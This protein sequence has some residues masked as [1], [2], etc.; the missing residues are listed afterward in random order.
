MY[1]RGMKQFLLSSLLFF[2]LT[3]PHASYGSTIDR[4]QKDSLRYHQTIA[5]NQ[6]LTLQERIRAIDKSIELSKNQSDSLYLS[7]VYYKSKIYGDAKEYDA[8][9]DQANILLDNAIKLS[10]LYYQAQAY[11]KLGWYLDRNQ[12]T[13]EAFKNY[14]KSID[15]YTEIKDSINIIKVS[16]RASFIQSQIGDLDGAE[17]T[18]VNAL[19]YSAALDDTSELSWFYD[20]LGRVYRERS[21][22]QEAISNHRKALRLE[23]SPA[24]RI[25]LLNNYAITLIK[26]SRFNEAITQLETVL[27]Y[28]DLKPRTQ[29][30]LLD[31]LAFAKAKLKAPDA[32]KLLE[33][34]LN[35]RKQSNDVAGQYAS[36]IHLSEAYG[37]IENNDNK[38]RYH[39]QQAYDIAHQ[40]KNKEARVRALDFLIPVTRESSKL[41]EERRRLADSLDAAQN[42]AKFE[43][44]KLR[45]DVEKAEERESLALRLQSASEL[46]EEIA[47]RRRNWAFA[48]LVAFILLGVVFILYQRERSR[49]QRIQD[50]Y[51]TEKRLSK[52]LHDELANEIYLV[53]S[54]VES[55]TTAPA[56]ADKLEHIY[57]LSRDISRE[58]QPIQTGTSF[59]TELA[60]SLQTYTSSERKLILRGLES[61]SWNSINDEKKIEIYRILQE[62]MTNMRKHSNAS[63]VALVFKEVNK[64]L[65]INY[66][67]NGKGVELTSY[68]RGSGLTNTET[69][70]KSVGGKITFDSAINEGFRAELSIPI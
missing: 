57:K 54:Q 1:F 34:A 48:G 32:I 22:W 46:R 18:I 44:A 24:S 10:N 38:V 12:K 60:L 5:K 20:V 37:S 27:E 67:D 36:H 31:N 25:S 58:T 2:I 62:L 29:H 11:N 7:Q 59:P 23:S 51:D 47:V 39:A 21:L 16:K 3:G 8:A 42:K 41:F 66:S 52:K 70:L 43:F 56:V 15:V 17:F 53:M 9:I 55:D 61:I 68:K 35:L 26:A 13:I 63:L 45:Y 69:R 30:R 28:E 33:E 50:R 14:V 65:E 49:K 19:D 6:E 4:Y 40:L 64:L